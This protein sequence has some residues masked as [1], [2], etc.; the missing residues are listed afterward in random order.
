MPRP[1]FLIGVDIWVANGAGDWVTRFSADDPTKVEKFKTGYSVSGM[2]MDSQG[3]VWVA[4]RLGNSVRGALVL[5]HMLWD[6]KVGGNPD[7][8]LTSAM[9]TQSPGYWEG[10]SVAVLRPDGSQAPCSPIKRQWFG[11]PVGCGCGWQRQYLGQQLR[12]R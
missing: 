12:Q 8:A 2:A 6:A 9:S 7:P 10:G 5:A 3:N 11:R 1:E 4:N